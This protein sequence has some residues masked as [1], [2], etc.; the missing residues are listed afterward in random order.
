MFKKFSKNR[1]RKM[2]NQHQMEEK[3]LNQD[4]ALEEQNTSEEQLENTTTSGENIAVNAAELA[5]DIGTTEE[6]AVVAQLEEDKIQLEKQVNELKDKY[7]RLVAEFDNFRKR[8]MKEQLEL[9]KVAARDT[10]SV[11]LPVLDDFNRAKKNAEE[12]QNEYFQQGVG[13]VINKLHNVLEQKGLMP[14]DTPAGTPFNP[15]LHHAL[16]EVPAANEE[17]KGKII[18]TVEKGYYLNETLIR[19][20][21]V[22]VGK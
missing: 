3:E 22:V 12:I 16:T 19:H 10:M 21:R 15:E 5:D 9:R 1:K 11:L 8:T 18:D 17:M 20:A 13:L 2:D 7:L 4:V 14:M 6:N